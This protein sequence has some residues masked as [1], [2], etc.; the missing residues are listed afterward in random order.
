MTNSK[1][2][3]RIV[4][5]LAVLCLVGGGAAFAQLQ[6]G[7]LYGTVVDEQGSALPGVT[8]TLSGNGAPQVQVTDSKGVFHFLSLS[9]SSYQLKAELEGFSTIEYPNVAINVGRNTQIEVTLSAA[10]EDVITVLGET[11]LLDERRI[12]TGATV[13]NTELEKIPTARDPWAVLQTTPGVL[14][15]RINVGG[16]ESGQQS[17]YVG[18]GS[19]GDQAIWAVDGVVIT[20]MAALGSS[21][22]YYDFDSFEEM[23]VTTGGSDSTIATGGVVL[24][25]VTKRG[26]N[27]WRGTGR[28]YKSDKAWQAK[29]SVDKGKLGKAGFFNGT[30]GTPGGFNQPD[31]KQGNQIDSVQ[32]YGA[33]L[34][35]PIV[36]DRLWVWGS[37]GDQKIDLRTIANVQDLTK[38]NTENVKFNAQIAANNSATVFG[39]QSEKKK[40]GR[41]AGPLRPQETT[42]DQSNFGDKPT[43]AK[44][45]DTHI[46]NSNFY[47]TGLYSIVNGGFQLAPEGGLDTTN[48]LDISTVYHNTMYLYQTKRPQRQAKLDASSFFNTGNLSHELKFGAGYRKADVE[49]LTRWGG[50]GHYIDKGFVGGPYGYLYVSRDAHPKGTNKYTSLY[51]QDTMSVGNLTANVGVRYDRQ[52]GTNEASSARAN[53]IF[54][55]ILPA[56]TYGGG[57]A[58]F[59]W[60][61]V[62]P[63]LGLTYALGAERK[64]LLRASYS[65]F[66]DQL[67]AASTFQTNPLVGLGYAYFYVN[68]NGSGNIGRGNVID[69]NGNGRIDVGDVVGSGFGSYTNPFTQ[70]LLN[71]STVNPNLRAPRTDELLL[72]VEHA[73]L[74]EFVVGLNLTY[75]KLSD[76]L[77]ADLNVFDGNP[78]SAENVLNT[79]R[80]ATRADYVQRILPE[81]ATRPNILPNGQHYNLVYYELKDGIASRGGTYLHNTDQEQTYKGASITF[82][83]RLSNRW[84]LRGNYSYAD[85]TWSKLDFNSFADPTHFL[86]GGFN[87]GDQVVQ[88]SGT[89][90]GA[91]GGVYINSKWSYSLNGLYQIAPDRPWGFNTALNLTGRQGYPIPYYVRLGNAFRQGIPG[92]TRVQVVDAP[93]SFRLDNIRILDGRLEKEFTFSDFGF[94]LSADCF[95]IF[96]EGFVQ[97]RQHR[98]RVG[99]NVNNP[100]APLSDYVTEVTSPRIFRLGARFSFR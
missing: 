75:R 36:K 60:T 9:P 54:P 56:V 40:H 26:T 85:W 64:T 59:T 33:E 73:L 41:N 77:R 52:K 100:L 81:S 45:E 71:S 76:L 83:K 78:Y 87:E 24:N 70:G 14:T 50:A 96:N 12:S 19:G 28:Y 5:V 82:N 72:S 48:F 65:R 63:R 8:V 53:P 62:T 38:L 74:P 89:G 58:G 25:M 95:N 44:V 79:G 23:Q 69:V 90:S 49:S 46:F 6:T 2:W 11:P 35:G 42:W 66:A 31:I 32:E 4:A 93:D 97:Q 10:V 20:D 30:A 21:P 51:A 15:D 39:L 34:G 29:T 86:G 7:N 27:E 80:A 61:D 94:T 16:N 67:G 47:L 55:D 91:K 88:G 84:M 98:L 18:P 68:Q 17:S 13:S 1:F 92:F 99:P 3:G 37:Y 43:A 22:A 57:D